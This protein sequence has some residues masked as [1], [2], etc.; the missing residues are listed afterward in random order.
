MGPAQI[1]VLTT[2]KNPCNMERFAVGGFLKTH[3][4][5]RYVT[6][7]AAGATA[8]ATG[9][10]TNNK[11]LSVAP[12]SQSLKT[13]LEYAEELGKS[14]GIVVTC[15]F[16]HATPAAFVS[17]MD[18]RNKYH[19]IAAQIVN[20]DID[21]I[22]GGAKGMHTADQKDL[23]TNEE[24]DYLYKKL[25]QKMKIVTDTSAFRALKDVDKLAYFYDPDVPG[26][27][28]ERPISLKEMTQKAIEIL[29]KN[30]SGFFLMVEGSQIDWASH[31]NEIDN[32]IGEIRDFDD[33]I[34]AGLDFAETDK[35][36]LVIVTA[37]HETGG[38]ALRDGSV[39]EKKIFDA[40]FASENHTA[41]MVP[42]FA[43]GPQ[44]EL[45]GGIHQNIF[46]GR[47]IIDF[48]RH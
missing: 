34:G 33:A 18:S 21:V 19:E 41:V 32:I 28:N 16:T 31:D 8:Y 14:T 17:H 15:E 24:N 44:S 38:L 35:N 39:T 2:V 20:S 1:T 26:K 42:V 29:S 43:F 10:K 13:V 46:I 12:D 30:A 9:Y 23:E 37:D 11:F 47:K 4:A 48:N 45:F 27:F 36:T 5:D 40:L 3:S 7:S 25:A 22:M 6:D